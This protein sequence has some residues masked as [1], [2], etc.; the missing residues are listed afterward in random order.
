[1]DMKE[2]GGWWW[3]GGMNTDSHN[4]K[5]AGRTEG[6]MIEK[7]QAKDPYYSKGSG[8]FL[9]FMTAHT[10]LTELLFLSKWG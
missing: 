1:M 7:D 2:V 8:H 4:N 9:I 3:G 10:V 5:G 6:G